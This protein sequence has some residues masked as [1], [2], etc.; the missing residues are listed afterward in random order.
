MIKIF[1]KIVLMSLCIYVLL[2]CDDEKSSENAHPSS[3]TLDCTENPTNNPN[4]Y[5]VKNRELPPINEVFPSGSYGYGDVVMFNWM[6]TV[7]WFLRSDNHKYGYD[8]DP[9]AIFSEKDDE[10]AQRGR[11][12]YVSV[13]EKENAFV[14]VKID[15][16]IKNDFHLYKVE[17]G[18]VDK[19][20]LVDA[21]EACSKNK[22]VDEVKLSEGDY[23]VYYG[24]EKKERYLHVISYPLQSEKVI[25][26]P[27]GDV[28]ASGCNKD[29]KN[30]CYTKDKVQPV[31]EK[32]FSQAVMKITLD[33]K[34]PEEIGLDKHL[35]VELS[36]PSPSSAVLDKIHNTET[37]GYLKELED[38][39]NSDD[40]TQSYA[41][42]TVKAK[43]NRIKHNK[44]VLAINQMRIQWQFNKESSD[45]FNNYSAL[46][47][48]IEKNGGKNLS[49]KMKSSC[50][51]GEV[52]VTFS[53]KNPKED[54]SFT[55]VGLPSIKNGC[56]Y[57]LY[58]DVV[59]FIPE[60]PKGAQVTHN[61]NEELFCESDETLDECNERTK[62]LPSPGGIVWGSHQEGEA[63]L[64]TLAHEIGHSF[65]LTDIYIAADD[66]TYAPHYA[67]YFAVDESNL[68]GWQLP[69]GM[70]LRYRPLFIASTLYGNLIDDPDGGYAIEKQWECVRSYKKCSS[71]K[72]SL[73]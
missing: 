73:K 30:G 15:P 6:E 54:G 23:V 60:Q 67:R 11:D 2:A 19:T 66:P 25:F 36:E 31:V 24:N 61:Y 20:D 5:V 1:I 21:K 50:G 49:M 64:N 37:Y 71:L 56:T 48:A 72:E 22:C 65:G 69:T 16:E 35:T 63:S 13:K 55:P 28:N 52:T 34:K 7:A 17:N 68:M 47:Q 10:A 59:P 33:E 58:A 45:E 39:Y 53:G 32:I 51:G 14:L 27:F 26:V 62:H 9:Y 43:Y 57:T 38:Y 8:M 41:Q 46:E 4:C 40:A 3:T 18:T 42:E 44:I 12:V 70:R 29:G